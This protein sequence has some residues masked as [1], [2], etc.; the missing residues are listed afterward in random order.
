MNNVGECLQC[1]EKGC[2]DQLGH[3]RACANPKMTLN[4]ALAPVVACTGGNVILNI[5]YPYLASQPDLIGP[6][7]LG[8][9]FAAAGESQ[10]V[11]G[12]MESILTM[13]FEGLKKEVS[14]GVFL[15]HGD[16]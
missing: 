11:V 5:L 9:H 10:T 4:L 14:V 12:T 7:T 3:S 2:H 16:E 13:D 8:A 1:D 15:Y 6:D